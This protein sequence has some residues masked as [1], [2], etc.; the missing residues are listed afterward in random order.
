MSLSPGPIPSPSA[1]EA[2]KPLGP[3]EL[4]ALAHLYRAEVYR[5][6]VWRTR[7]DTTTN[8]AIVTLGLALSLTFSDPQASPLPLLLVGIL[9]A[10][11]LLLEA[12][13]YRYYSVWRERS[14]LMERR[15]FVPLLRDGDL[16][17]EGDWRRRLAG[18]YDDP[19]FQ[20]SLL[21][22][23]ARRVRSNY[24][25]IVLVQ[26]LAYVGKLVVHPTAATLVGDVF[27][28]AAIGPIPG[29][30]IALL[31]GLYVLTFLG[32]ALWITWADARRGRAGDEPPRG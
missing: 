8:W 16:R 26:V 7:L 28:R 19:D 6:T 9:I 24:L 27:G 18:D 30:L 17:G 11:F 3:A 14:R 12:R 13:R 4:G 22:A 15:L 23:V 29:L 32:L 5:G 1:P 20:V 21:T 10:L 25:W 31:G 2:P